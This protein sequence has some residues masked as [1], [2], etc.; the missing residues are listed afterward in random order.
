MACDAHSVAWLIPLTEQMQVGEPVSF[1][2]GWVDVRAQA[3]GAAPVVRVRADGRDV[4]QLSLLWG[5]GGWRSQEWRPEQAG[6]YA[7]MLEVQRV[8]APPLQAQYA[9][10]VS[11]PKPPAAEAG[12]SPGPRISATLVEHGGRRRVETIIDVPPNEAGEVG[13]YFV[14]L[15]D[16]EPGTIAAI[17]RPGGERTS[18]VMPWERATAPRQALLIRCTNE[19]AGVVAAAPIAQNANANQALRLEG[20][21]QVVG[22]GTAEICYAWERA[23]GGTGR[24]LLCL[25]RAAD[26]GFQA[27]GTDTELRA[28]AAEPTLACAS[29]IDR[30]SKPG[31]SELGGAGGVGG[32]RSRSLE[33]LVRPRE[34]LVWAGIEELAGTSGVLSVPIPAQGRFFRL[35]AVAVK[36][37]DAQGEPALL[38]DVLLDAG[39]AL[40]IA[41]DFPAFCSVGDRPWA[42]AV[43]RNTSAVEKTCKVELSGSNGLTVEGVV[44][45]DAGIQPERI[46]S[47]TI[48]AGGV[49]RVCWATEVAGE[50]AG[51]IQTVVQ[52]DGDAQTVQRRFEIAAA[53]QAGGRAVETGNTGA[54]KGAQVRIGRSLFLMQEEA[55]DPAEIGQ[56]QT[57]SWSLQALAGDVTLKS[58]Q[59]VLVREEIELAQAIRGLTWRQRLPGTALGKT[60]PDG[61]KDW[62]QIAQL[63]RSTFAAYEFAA[64]ALGAGV[65]RHH[66]CLRAGRPGVCY[67]P[68]PEV[69]SGNQ[70]VPVEMREEVR[71]QVLSPGVGSEQGGG[72]RHGGT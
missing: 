41:L 27:M 53:P 47:L 26:S 59:L 58:G 21:P 63:R 4:A 23:A 1:W 72:H 6:S 68:P 60:L 44:G 40:Q 7:A 62:V 16:E 42:T 55:R 33:R 49:R 70:S 37:G 24:V 12:V 9:F 13:G 29:S 11:I 19:G 50:G 48:A 56:E 22:G 15:T 35:R 2:A 45:G 31:S 66:Y 30:R 10:E 20:P 25:T 61:Q 34:D 28:D 43:I 51:Q 32:A 54:N 14:C 65:H 64:P 36:A 8:S 38:S 57:R 3:M 39:D 46:V 18:F 5:A 67:L 17:P 69:L 71:I 52:T